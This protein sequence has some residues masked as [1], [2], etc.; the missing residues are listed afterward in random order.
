[1]E[2]REPKLQSMT[3]EKVSNGIAYASLAC[4]LSFWPMLALFYLQTSLHFT[5]PGWH[6]LDGLTT[7]T[8]FLFEA[9][10]LLLAIVSTILRSRL[11]RIALPV[12]F[13]MFLFVDYVM[14]S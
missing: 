8:W 14:V 13:L 9:F 6:W 12:T 11:W 2:K 1:M 10:A 4:S 3:K 5:L 7:W